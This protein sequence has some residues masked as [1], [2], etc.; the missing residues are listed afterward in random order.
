VSFTYRAGA[1]LAS[2]NL[3]GGVEIGSIRINGVSDGTYDGTFELHRLGGVLDG[4][5][6]L[7]DAVNP[8][9]GGD[10]GSSGYPFYNPRDIILEGQLT[11]PTLADIWSA[12][13]LLKSNFNIVGIPGVVPPLVQLTVNTTGWANKRFLMVRPSGI[14]SWVEPDG[15]AKLEP[16]RLFSQPLVAPD[17]L[18][19]NA[20]TLQSVAVT[21]TNLTNNGNAN[22]PFVVRFTGPST[23]PTLS[24]P[25]LTGREIV[26]TGTIASGHYVEVGTNPTGDGSGL[27][28][29]DNTG[30][31][32]WDNL[33]TFTCQVIPPGTSAWGYSG[34]GTCTVSFRDAWL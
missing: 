20:D 10:G 4:G 15:L 8:L 22:A 34:G 1:T 13:D 16:D 23:N 12:L 5:P 6:D 29:V 33:T 32:V 24:G 30:A 7:R 3:A 14:L 18:M 25:G 17:P 11:V 26:Y 21:T 2:P 28:A 9:P 27:Y 31:D 19:Y